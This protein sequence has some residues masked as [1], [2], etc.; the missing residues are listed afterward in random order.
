M[1]QRLQNDKLL[2]IK[3]TKNKKAEQYLIPYMSASTYI[4]YKKKYKL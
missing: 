1:T 3:I 2:M 4:I